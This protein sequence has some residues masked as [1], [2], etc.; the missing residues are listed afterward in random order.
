MRTLLAQ[1]SAVI[2]S[3]P[4][5]YTLD[6][7][8]NYLSPAHFL[9]GRPL[10]TVPDPDL[11]HIPVGRLGYWQSIQ[12][13]LQGFWKK[14]HQEYLTTLQQRPKW[15]NSTPNISTGD[16]VLVK[17]SNSPPASWHIARVM[18]TYPGKDDL[19]R[20]VKLK[21]PTGEMTRPITKVAVLPHSETVFQGGPGCS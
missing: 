14:W 20:A 11:S 6:T 10:T 17:E 3:R 19:V 12:S 13:M 16:V 5:C 18:E 2:N 4:L 1:I 21:T 15:T 7:E 9:I 8:T